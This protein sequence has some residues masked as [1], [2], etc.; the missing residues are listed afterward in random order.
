MLLYV[1]G[2]RSA[3]LGDIVEI[4]AY[5]GRSTWYLAQA[6]KDAGSA[7]KLVSI[8][9]QPDQDVREAYF[10]MLQ[11]HQLTQVVE[12]KLAQSHT[13][14]VSFPERPIGLLWIDGDHS[15]E[16]VRQDFDDWF[17]RL[18]TGGWL[19]LHDTVNNWHGPTKLARELLARRSDL[20]EVGVVF[21]TLF[22]RKAPAHTSNR[23]SALKART[24][25]ELLTLLQ[26]RHAGFGPQTR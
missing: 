3:E 14:A 11:Q 25:F 19:A 12:P 20:V 1:L 22:A 4:G 18:A 13:V 16:A 17:P 21:L 6:L 9:P 24:T 7:H 10:A 5:K 26:A 2:R 23:L 8:D 15:Y